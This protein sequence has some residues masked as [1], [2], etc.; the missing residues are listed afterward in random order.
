MN[1]TIEDTFNALQ[2]VISFEQVDC[3]ILANYIS[4]KD[5]LTYARDFWLNSISNESQKLLPNEYDFLLSGSNWLE[6]AEWSMQFGSKENVEML[7]RT[8]LSGRCARTICRVI[9]WRGNQDINGV[10]VCVGFS[11]SCFASLLTQRRRQ[12]QPTLSSHL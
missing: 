9:E 4:S 5:S 6:F 10:G 3:T 2:E 1:S 12:S 11:H 7:N 8:I